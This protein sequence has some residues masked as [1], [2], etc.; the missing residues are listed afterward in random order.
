MKYSFVPIFCHWAS[1]TD[2]G[3]NAYKFQVQSAAI[4]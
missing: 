3:W 1:S 4:L 2:G